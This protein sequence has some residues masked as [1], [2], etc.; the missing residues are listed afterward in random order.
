MLLP[1]TQFVNKAL[2][3]I[4]AGP[5]RAVDPAPLWWW[6]LYNEKKEDDINYSF[7]ETRYTLRLAVLTYPRLG[8]LDKRRKSRWL[9]SGSSGIASQIW[10][11][12]MPT[13]IRTC[14]AWAQQSGDISAFMERPTRPLRM[15]KL[16]L[17]SWAQET[18][19][20]LKDASLDKDFCHSRQ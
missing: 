4:W 20:Q 3:L 12:R 10:F 7:D 19:W 2:A 17:C 9:S 1:R 8:G 14:S 11:Q 15:S 13:N 16:L 18:M 5:K 6:S